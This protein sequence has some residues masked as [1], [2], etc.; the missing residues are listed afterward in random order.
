MELPA[1]ATP[2]DRMMW[3]LLAAIVGVIHDGPDNQRVFQRLEAACR[4]FGVPEWDFDAVARHLDFHY[5]RGW[6]CYLDRETYDQVVLRESQG[7][8]GVH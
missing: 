2:R 8:G 3:A 6:D 5:H 1:D 7:L 4:T